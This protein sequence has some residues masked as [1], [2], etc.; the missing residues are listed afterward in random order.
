[1][2]TSVAVR[3]SATSSKRTI[4]LS[5]YVAEHPAVRVFPP[6]SERATRIAMLTMFALIAV[7]L[8]VLVLDEAGL[9]G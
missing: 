4:P 9:F 5:Q 8:L 6:T 2:A 3:S 7:S 1:M